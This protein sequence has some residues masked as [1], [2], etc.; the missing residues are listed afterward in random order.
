LMIAV[1]CGKNQVC[2]E[3]IRRG[4]HMDHVNL[5]G[6]TALHLAVSLGHK[7]CLSILLAAGACESIEN[8]LRQTAWQ[9]GDAA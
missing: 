4:C 6:N 5:E 8:R 1:K 2:D 9:L 3:L 7:I